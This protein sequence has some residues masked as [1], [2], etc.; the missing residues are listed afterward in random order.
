MIY[1]NLHVLDTDSTWPD[2]RK[3]VFSLWRPCI[4]TVG[5]RPSSQWLGYYSEESS[6]QGQS[7]HSSVYFV[8]AQNYRFQKFCS[9]EK[10]LEDTRALPDKFPTIHEQIVETGMRIWLIPLH[11]LSYLTHQI[12]SDFQPPAQNFRMIL[13]CPETGLV[14]QWE[15][16]LSILFELKSIVFQLLLMELSTSVLILYTSIPVYSKLNFPSSSSL[17]TQQ[18]VEEYRWLSFWCVHRSKIIS[19]KAPKCM[20]SLMFSIVEEFQ[21]VSS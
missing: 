1:P 9:A 5:F 14:I 17:T 12:I 6:K 18:C 11:M 2:L 19:S 4:K 3:R 16:Q 21:N 15:L 13:F 7:S 20:K 8:F 10:Y